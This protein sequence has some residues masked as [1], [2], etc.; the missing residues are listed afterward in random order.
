MPQQVLIRLRSISGSRMMS[1]TIGRL[2][3]ARR[4]KH[5]ALHGGGGRPVFECLSL[6]AAIKLML[7]MSAS[8]C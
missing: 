2:L 1:T 4:A 7:W 5:V 3:T 6:R 8:D